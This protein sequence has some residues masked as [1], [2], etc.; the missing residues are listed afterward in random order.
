M[1]GR[2]CVRLLS[3]PSCWSRS[4]PRGPA[5]GRGRMRLRRPRWRFGQQASWPAQPQDCIFNP[6]LGCCIFNPW[7]AVLGSFL[8]SPLGARR[9][10]RRWRGLVL[11][12]VWEWACRPEEAP[13]GESPPHLPASAANPRDSGPSPTPLTGEGAPQPREL[14]VGIGK[15]R[16]WPA[17]RCGEGMGQGGEDGHSGSLNIEEGF[18]TSPWGPG[19]LERLWG[20][21]CEEEGVKRKTDRVLEGAQGQETRGT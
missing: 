21:C 1:P 15:V 16:R 6:C 11:A 13:G 12:V 9:G 14:R 4:G 8:V 2:C 17:G 18:W 10:E 20:F 7:R 5:E 19:L 3:S